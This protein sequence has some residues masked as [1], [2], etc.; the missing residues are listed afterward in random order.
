M[1]ASEARSNA[2]RCGGWVAAGRPAAGPHKSGGC[3]LRWLA[4]DRARELEQAACR[5]VIALAEARDDAAMVAPRDLH[6]LDRG[7]ADLAERALERAAL[8]TACGL[9]SV[10]VE[11]QHG[12]RVAAQ[13]AH[14]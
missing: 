3:D 1:R 8:L 4:D 13:V 14:G 2:K 6:A 5:F 9:V 7:R 12:R 11:Q 10:G